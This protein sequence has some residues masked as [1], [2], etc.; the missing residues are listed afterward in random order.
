MLDL[1]GCLSDQRAPQ[2]TCTNLAGFPSHK[3]AALTH[4]GIADKGRGGSTAG[5]VG[6]GVLLPQHFSGCNFHDSPPLHVMVGLSD[7]ESSCVRNYGQ[8][9]NHLLRLSQKLQEEGLPSPKQLFHHLLLS[10]PA[11]M[12]AALTAVLADIWLR[13]C[14]RGEREVPL[15]HILGP[16]VPC[17]LSSCFW[18][19]VLLMLEASSSAEMSCSTH[20]QLLHLLLWPLSLAQEAHVTNSLGDVAEFL[21]LIASLIPFSA[22]ERCK[23]GNSMGEGVRSLAAR[24]HYTVLALCG[25]RVQMVQVSHL[26]LQLAGR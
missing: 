6:A 15:K 4:H 11:K 22:C 12:G 8:F 1:V 16:L 25:F 21:E 17:A 19:V 18:P 13:W 24:A 7:S 14:V 26:I 5:A 3:Q 10:V 23:G 2:F 9:W 20:L